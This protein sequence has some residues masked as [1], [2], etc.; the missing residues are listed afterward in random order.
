[1]TTKVESELQADR[2]MRRF[3]LK[4]V[5]VRGVVALSGDLPNEAAVN[6]AKAVALEV[7][8]VKHVDT[9]GLSVP[10]SDQTP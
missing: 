1:M 6:H 3:D 8:G 5:T 7:D 2:F 9:T 4:V 10:G